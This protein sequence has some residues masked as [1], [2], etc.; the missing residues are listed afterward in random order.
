MQWLIKVQ[1]L[2]ANKEKARWQSGWIA[3]HS[4]WS[5]RR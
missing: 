5:R 2:E 3:E 4:H 1:G